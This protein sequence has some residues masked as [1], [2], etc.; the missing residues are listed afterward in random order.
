MY[1]AG[2]I[3]VRPE[4]HHVFGINQLTEA[5]TFFGSRGRLGT[6]SLSFEGKT[7]TTKVGV[8]ILVVMYG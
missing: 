6:V 5:F 2:Y 7:M 3:T 8:T 4:Y 1:R